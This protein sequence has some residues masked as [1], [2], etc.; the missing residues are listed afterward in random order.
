MNALTS[1]HR[2]TVSLM[3]A[4]LALLGSGS[5]ARAQTSHALVATPLTAMPFQIPAQPLDNAL[6][7]LARAA[8]LQLMAPPALLQDRQSSRV[9]GTLSPQAAVQQ[10]LQGTGLAGRISGS[11]LI[12]AAASSDTALQEVTVRSATH[13]LPE[14]YAG[15]QI[16]RGGSL[17][18]LGNSDVLDTPFSVVS[19]TS[20]LLENQQ[21]RTLADVMVNDASVR[22]LTAAGGFGDSFQIRGFN[23]ANAESFLND[24]GG[25]TAT[26]NIPTE[27]IERVELLKG[28][29]A[30]ARGMA[31]EGSIGGSINLVT[32]RAGDAPLTR[33]TTRYSSQSQIGTHLDVGRRFGQDKAWGVRFNGVLRNGESSIDGGKQRIGLAALGL[34]YRSSQ[35]RWSLDTFTYHDDTQEFRPQAMVRFGA[36]G[37]SADR[38]PTAPDSRLNFYP[39]SAKDAHTTTVLSRLEYDATDHLTLLAGLGYARFRV[40]QDFPL[41]ALQ[42]TSGSMLVSNAVYDDARTTTA[43][44]V[45]LRA[46]LRTGSVDHRLAFSHNWLQRDSGYYYAALGSSN[47]SIYQPTPIQSGNHQPPVKDSHLKQQGMALTDTLALLNDR[48]QVTLGLRHQ[49]IQTRSPAVQTRT[50]AN[51]PLAGVVIKPTEQLSLYANYTAGLTDGGVAPMGAANANQ[52]I[53]P[54]QSKQLEVGIK[55][56]WGKLMTQVAL[57]QIKKPTSYQDPGSGIYSYAGEQRNR[58]LELSLYGEPQ[59]G[60]RVMASVAFTQA[61]LTRIED[62]A[63][64]GQRAPNVPRHMLSMGADWDVPGIPGL[65]LNG[66]ALHV[67]SVHLNNANTLRVPSWTRF[68]VGARYAIQVA[69]QPVML[70]ATLENLTNRHY[71]LT[72][73]VSSMY[74]YAMV[75]AP[76]TLTLSASIDF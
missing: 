65:S 74:S 29:G 17:G 73:T 33:L 44:D 62:A 57:F 48:M 42:D 26:T 30:L 47:S 38:L 24:F 54:Y 15:G 9:Q 19:F 4:A 22:S 45:G 76:R 6:A 34:D 20:E 37:Y 64:Q 71:W 70:R 35:V 53:A 40:N 36:G 1:A 66:R 27:L 8:G 25:L 23:V 16:A 21:T 60:L 14:A 59:R 61:Q 11:T 41:G 28:P 50:S 56:D 7:Q 18:V 55:R 32:K 68:D 10:L 52:V 69:G 3:L 58:G 63:V 49:T 13:S 5:L 75:S 31:P 2:H 72:Q 43:A 12:I 39:G 67:A 46:S 51:S